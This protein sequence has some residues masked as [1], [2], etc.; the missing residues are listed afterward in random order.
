MLSKD[1]L[2]NQVNNY[3]YKDTVF[4]SITVY[5]AF[6]HGIPMFRFVLINFILQYK[7]KP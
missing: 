5:S 3:Q 7:V 4:R 6:F 2:K 1:P